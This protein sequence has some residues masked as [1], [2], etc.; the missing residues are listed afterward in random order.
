MLI[1]N[2]NLLFIIIYFIIFLNFQ[3][4]KLNIKLKLI[5]KIILFLYY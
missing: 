1:L 2:M 3:L 5:N 4:S